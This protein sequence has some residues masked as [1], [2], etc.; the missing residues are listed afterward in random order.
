MTRPCSSRRRTRAWCRNAERYYRAM[1]DRRAIS[2][3]LRDRHMMETLSA[4]DQFLAERGHAPGGA[5]KL[6]VWAHNSHVGDASATAMADGGE[7]NIGQLARAT[8]G[9]DAALVGFSTYDGTVTAADEWDGAASRMVVRPALP[10]S[11]EWLM[12]ETGHAAMHVDLHGDL[13]EVLRTPRLAR[14]I[15]VIY[16]PQTERQSHYYSVS[17]SRQFDALLH[18]DRTRAVEPLERRGEPVTGELPETYPS[19]L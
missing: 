13:Q 7:I 2:W 8:Y 12:H 9:D 14:A 1:F 10:E 11:V 5:P 19:T 15:G 16:R 4:L 18:Y 3:N 6:V 17:L